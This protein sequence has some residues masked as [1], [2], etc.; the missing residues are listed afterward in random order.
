[1]DTSVVSTSIAYSE[2]NVAKKLDSYTGFMTP[3]AYFDVLENLS[4]T[5]TVTIKATPYFIDKKGNR[6]D[7]E[8][9][10]VVYENGVLKKATYTKGGL[11]VKDDTATGYN[12]PTGAAD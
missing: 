6:T 4:A 7:G 3:Y 8:E 10:T 1:M 5:A 11:T 2:E 12:K 9:Y